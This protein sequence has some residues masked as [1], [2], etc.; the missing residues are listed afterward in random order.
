MLDMNLTEFIHTSNVF[1]DSPFPNSK[2]FASAVQ[3][4][5]IADKMG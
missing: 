1:S 3:S 2:Q 4:P 5:L